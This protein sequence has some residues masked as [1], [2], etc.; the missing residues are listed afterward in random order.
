[1]DTTT[2][3]E[4]DYRRSGSI[5]VELCWRRTTNELSVTVTDLRSAKRIVIPVAR[6][7][8]R[9]AFNHPYA[10]AASIGMDLNSR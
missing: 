3:L 4:L 2:D 9:Q 8:A 1:M 5:E 7:L 10:Y 6:N